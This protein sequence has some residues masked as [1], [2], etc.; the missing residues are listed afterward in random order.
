MGDFFEKGGTIGSELI[1]EMVKMGLALG[2]DDLEN[3][4]PVGKIIYQYNKALY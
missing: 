1:T 4:T 2:R 3:L